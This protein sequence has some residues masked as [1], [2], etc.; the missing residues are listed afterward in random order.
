MVNNDVS[1]YQYNPSYQ[2]DV[3]QAQR[4]QPQQRSEESAETRRADAIENRPQSSN[5]SYNLGHN[6]DTYA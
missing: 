5:M 6:I 4:V 1:R 2:R 3:S